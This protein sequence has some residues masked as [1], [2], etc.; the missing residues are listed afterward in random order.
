MFL[1]MFGMHGMKVCASDVL[2]M[3]CPCGECDIYI[4]WHIYMAYIYVPCQC[5][6]CL[7]VCLYV[8]IC[9]CVA[10]HCCACYVCYTCCVCVCG[11]G[12]G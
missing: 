8:C 9:V 12:R 6:A 1:H 2:Y 11:I 4:I 10:S 7:C 5:V 3:R